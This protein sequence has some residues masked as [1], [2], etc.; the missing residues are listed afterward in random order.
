MTET[1][2]LFLSLTLSVDEKG[3]HLQDAKVVRRIYVHPSTIEVIAQEQGHTCITLACGTYYCVKESAE[4][5]SEL[6]STYERSW[7]SVVK[8][9]LFDAL[10]QIP[11]PGAKG[12]S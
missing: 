8:R 7:R 9:A 1:N 4:S 11:E 12:R 6:V 5:I 10:E 2:N 3:N